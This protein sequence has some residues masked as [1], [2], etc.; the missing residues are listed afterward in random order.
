MRITRPSILDVEFIVPDDYERSHW[1]ALDNL[2]GY[3]DNNMMIVGLIGSSLSDDGWLYIA[4]T[5][6]NVDDSF[7][8]DMISDIIGMFDTDI[9]LITDVE[10]KQEKIASSLRRYGF[11]QEYRDGIMYS[12]R[13]KD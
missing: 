8:K 10:S 1:L 2:T 13:N 11:R 9:C 6:K 4:S 5:V 7:T 3:F 12:Y